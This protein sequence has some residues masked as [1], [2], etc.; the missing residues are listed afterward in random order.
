MAI[1][2]VLDFVLFIVLLVGMSSHFIQFSLI[3]EHLLAYL[4]LF[5]QTFMVY[6]V[7]TESI[8]FIFSLVF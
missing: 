4:I 1:L 7:L 2:A 3:N 8:T 5:N 6:L